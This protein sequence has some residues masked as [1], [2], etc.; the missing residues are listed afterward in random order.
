MVDIR[1]GEIRELQ[2]RIYEPPR[3]FEKFLEEREY[4]DIYPYF[5]DQALEAN[6]QQEAA[7]YQK[8]IDSERQHYDWFRNAMQE[9]FPQAATPA[10]A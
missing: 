9:Y 4:S 1:A 3:Y 8:V 5:R 6:S 10:T 7:V 2:L